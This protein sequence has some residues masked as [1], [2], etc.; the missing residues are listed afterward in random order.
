M[1]AIAAVSVMNCSWTQVKRSGRERPSRH[2]AGLGA[3]HGRVGVL[4]QERGDRRA[5]AQVAAVAGQD[6]P[7]AR[8]VELAHRRVERIQPLDQ[9]LVQAIDDAVAPQRAAALDLPG[10]GH[11]RQAGDRVDARGP[12]ARAREAVADPDVAA[13]GGAVEP[14]EGRDLV[15]PGRR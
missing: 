7:E 4:D 8:L 11:R 13:L 14:G 9:G 12:V 2:F 1:S 15:R 5:V 3:D 10:A 6:R